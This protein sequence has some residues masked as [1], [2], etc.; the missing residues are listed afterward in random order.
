MG[1][2]SPIGRQLR[3]RAPTVDALP[4][5][6]ERAQRT[7][8]HRLDLLAQRR[9]S[10]A[11]LRKEIEPVGERALSAFM[12]SWQGV[13]RWRSGSELPADRGSIPHSGHTAGSPIGGGVERLREVLVPLQGL[14]LPV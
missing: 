6:H 2:R 14:V 9:A 4:R 1:Y 10:L 8:A 11:A 5:R 7:L 3:T 13:D 12:P